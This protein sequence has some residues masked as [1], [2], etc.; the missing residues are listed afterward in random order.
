MYVCRC[1]TRQWHVG[2]YVRTYI[3]TYNMGGCQQFPA[4]RHGPTPF[5]EAKPSRVPLSVHRMMAMVRNSIM[6]LQVSVNEAQA[7]ASLAGLEK[8]HEAS[9]VGLIGEDPGGL[10]AGMLHAGPR[11]AT[12]SSNFWQHVVPTAGSR[13]QRVRQ[14]QRVRSAFAA[15]THAMRGEKERQEAWGYV[16]MLP[17]LWACRRLHQP[18]PGSN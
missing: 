13:L 11:E 3:H 2:M 6:T 7:A 9:P 17:P 16:H 12:R 8:S 4:A 10:A 1:G 18:G 5:L 14:P 15:S